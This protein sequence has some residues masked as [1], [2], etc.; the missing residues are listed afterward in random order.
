MFLLLLAITYKAALPPGPGP[1]SQVKLAQPVPGAARALSR[2]GWKQGKLCDVSKAPYSAKN[3]T[4]ST[5]IL[6]RAIDDCGDLPG[7]GTALVPS[8]LWLLTGRLFLR[9]N[10]LTFRVEKV[11]TLL[12]WN[13]YRQ[14]QKQR[15][16]Y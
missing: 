3:G 14:R 4:N 16:N 10:N 6:Q 5:T 11:A 15:I 7:G 9:S 13:S 2:D 8:G 1:F 12:A